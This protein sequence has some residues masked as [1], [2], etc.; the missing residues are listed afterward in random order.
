M[1]ELKAIAICL[2]I[3]F[4]LDIIMAFNKKRVGVL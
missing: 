1:N 2:A 4:I 3:G